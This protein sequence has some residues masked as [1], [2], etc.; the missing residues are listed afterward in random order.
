[1]FFLSFVFALSL[2]VQAEAFWFLARGERRVLED[3]RWRCCSKLD[4][5]TSAGSPSIRTFL[6][7]S[8]ALFGLDG[9]LAG[10]CSSL[11]FGV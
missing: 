10:P 1:L 2:L 9:H 4:L 11:L 7:R 3:G 8:S 5:L 6:L